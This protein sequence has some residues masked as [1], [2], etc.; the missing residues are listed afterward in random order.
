MSAKPENMWGIT[1]G[2]SGEAIVNRFHQ[3]SI[4]FIAAAR[5]VAQILA[6]TRFVRKRGTGIAE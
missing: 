1:C 4:K 6:V 2:V 5:L 3:P